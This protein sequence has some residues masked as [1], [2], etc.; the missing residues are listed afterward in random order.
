MQGDRREG[1]DRRE[2]N[3]A[4]ITLGE[5]YRLCERI[6]GRMSA[7][8]DG[9]DKDVHSLRGRIDEHHVDIALLQQQVNNLESKGRDWRGWIAS[10]LIGGL[11]AMLPYLLEALKR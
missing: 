1:V 2:E 7:L 3:V 11:L 10:G 8:S 5:V 9:I 6:E 4:T